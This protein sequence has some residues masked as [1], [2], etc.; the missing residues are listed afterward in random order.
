MDVAINEF[1]RRRYESSP[2]ADTGVAA[3]ID[4]LVAETVMK[5]RGVDD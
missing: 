2:Q 3:D 1:I 4:Q 5:Y